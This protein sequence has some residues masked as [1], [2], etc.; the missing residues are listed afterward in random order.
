[1]SC[2]RWQNF[3]D[4]NQLLQEEEDSFG[5]PYGL[6]VDGMKITALLIIRKFI[7][8]FTRYSLV[9]QAP[10]MIICRVFK[11][12]NKGLPKEG[13]LA[14]RNFS[15]FSL[16]DGPIERLI[17][18]FTDTA[19]I[20]NLLDLRSIMGCPGGTRSLSTNARFSSKNRTSLYISRKKAIIITSK[21]GTTI[22]FLGK[23]GKLEYILSEYI[24]SCSCPLASHN[25]P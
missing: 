18:L 6:H 21:Q 15:P 2:C 1:M 8:L 13:L 7:F 22:F 17:D 25:A 11:I 23:L 14:F 3:T 10:L 4:A 24:G 20:L 16:G 5:T 19:A 9:N 12:Y